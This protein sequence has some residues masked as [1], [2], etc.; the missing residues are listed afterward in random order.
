MRV[1]KNYEDW[2]LENYDV[3]HEDYYTTS[4]RY[5]YSKTWANGGL[6]HGLLAILFANVIGIVF[7]LFGWNS[8]FLGPTDQALCVLTASFIFY[9]IAAYGMNLEAIGNTLYIFTAIFGLLTMGKLPYWQQA[10]CSVLAHAAHIGLMVVL[11][12][13][14]HVKYK[15]FKKRNIDEESGRSA[16]EEQSYQQW[17]NSYDANRKGLPSGNGNKEDPVVA[18]ARKLFEGYTGNPQQLKQRYRQLAKQ[19]HPDRL[20][21][22]ADDSM[23]KAI[24][25][26]FEELQNKVGKA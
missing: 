8:T 3:A 1:S 20:G 19:Y 18:E 13:Y 15:K 17:K 26:V 6:K 2:T 4:A 9:G 22:G 12:I 11:P 16:K 21:E 7:Q 14:H 5:E 10:V 23:F 25:Y 24:R